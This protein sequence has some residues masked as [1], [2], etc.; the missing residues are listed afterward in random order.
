MTT[1]RKRDS[2]YYKAVI[3]ASRAGDAAAADELV[4]RLAPD[5][6]RW[7]ERYMGPQL[8]RFLSVTDIAQESL[9]RILGPLDHMRPDG[10]L[11]DVRGLLFQNAR[12]IILSRGNEARRFC[13]ESAVG[14]AC[15]PD[16]IAPEADRSTNTVTLED[17]L[18]W[19]SELI[20][21]MDGDL[22]NVLHGRLDGVGFPELAE[23]LELTESAVRKRFQRA[24]EELGRLAEARDRRE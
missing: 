5:L 2:A 1:E 20:V 12:W 17:E 16:Q 8:K 3:A 18:R 4:E 14:E 10:D 23:R 22:A 11:D 9:T 21:E 19:M 15:S 24:L 6:F 13:G 7:L